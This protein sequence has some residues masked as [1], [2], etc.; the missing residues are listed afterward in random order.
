MPRHD[1]DRARSPG[2]P[3][4]SESDDQ[5]S[6]P[7]SLQALDLLVAGTG[8]ELVTFGSR[9]RKGGYFLTLTELRAGLSFAPVLPLAYDA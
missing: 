3:V 4:G 8:F 2:C 5:K 9:A 6:R 1:R 7:A